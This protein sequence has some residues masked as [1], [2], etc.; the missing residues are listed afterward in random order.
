MQ[1][2]C[3]VL[4]ESFNAECRIASFSISLGRNFI[5]AGNGSNVRM[6]VPSLRS[7]DASVSYGLRVKD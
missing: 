7:V 1:Q 2:E 4:S 3:S 5:S 6:T